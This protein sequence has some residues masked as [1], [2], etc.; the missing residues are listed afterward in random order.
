MANEQDRDQP[1]R[2]T[3]R[4][5]VAGTAV[6]GAAVALPAA[7]EAAR[8]KQR[9][10]AQKP[11]RP[12]PTHQADVTVVG[13]G[14]AG[15]TAARAIRRA[16]RS[17]IV[18]EAR[19]RVGGRC[20]SRSIGAHASDVANMGATF[21]GPTQLKIQALMRELGIG[22]FPTFATG[23]L[24]FFENGKN[25]PYTGV[26][27]P[28]SDPVAVIELGAVTLPALD[29]M[30]RTVPLAAPHTAPNAGVW[31]AMT[32]DTWARQ[33]IAASEGRKLFALAVEAALSVEPRDI[34]FL[35]LLF[36]IHSA[37]STHA[38]F[39]NAGGGG[40]QD[41][42]VSGGTQGIA[43]QIARRLGP[44]RVLLGHPVRGIV[45]RARGATVHADNATVSCRRVVVA[46]PPHLA[47]RIVYTPQLPA[48][49]DQLT[50]R[51]PIGSLIKTIGVYDKPFWRAQ[52]LNGQVTS[53]QGPV[54]VTFDASP[55]SGTPGVMLGFVDGD[56][57]RALSDLPGPA[58]RARELESYVRYFGARAGK[59]RMFFDQVWDREIY[60]GGCPVGVMP[61]G[62]MTEYGSILRT[63]QGR[64]HW[65]G[66]ETATV[67]NGYMDGAV[68][69]G[70]RAA[71]EVLKEL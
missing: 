2:I 24:L 60:T 70:E 69:S 6:T 53:D 33:N 71:A 5:F 35:Y 41:F 42:R 25:T 66:T 13:A 62:V 43:I 15:L 19:T 18:L 39:A 55:A 67:W 50:Q 49:R 29:R 61:T 64:I 21:I 4:R 63:P 17:V 20:F 57:A 51:M 3:R 11:H 46:L 52:G 54:K 12:S 56:D 10:P 59:P 8:A 58:R 27:P 22:R 1:S 45:Q 32:A 47:G 36:Y 9:S 68:Q 7:A 23:K 48:L 26:V 34:S 38:L 30:A 40:A 16:G 37:G 65:A 14:L 31:D 28:A 44:T